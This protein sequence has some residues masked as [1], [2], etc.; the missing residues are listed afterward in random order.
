MPHIQAGGLKAFAVT[1]AVRSS[2]LPDTPTVAEAG[3]L[4][5]FEASSWFGLLA[6]AGTP[7]EVVNRL[8]QET[9]KALNL[10]NVKERLVAQGAIPSGNTPQE[11]G[12]L[13]EAEIAKWAPV[14]KASGAKVD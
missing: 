2:A 9:A 13:I 6:P 14:V 3:A 7:P 8:Q 10:P 1:S 5:G 4:A 11:F 12:K